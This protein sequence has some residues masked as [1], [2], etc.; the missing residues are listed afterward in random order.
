MSMKMIP[1]LILAS[2][3]GIGSISPAAVPTAPKTVSSPSAAEHK[4]EL[5]AKDAGVTMKLSDD[6]Q[7]HFKYDSSKFTV[8]DS[9]AKDTRIISVQKKAGAIIRSKDTV[10]VDIPNTTYSSITAIVEDAALDLHA[11]NSDLTMTSRSG[12]VSIF[13]PSK[14]TKTVQYTSDS[15]A[16]SIHLNGN[17][18]FTVK[19]SGLDS[20]ASFPNGWP[21]WKPSDSSIAGYSYQ[22][23]KG[24]AKFEIRLNDSAL[25]VKE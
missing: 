17:A 25:S 21:L 14:F 9:A 18:N 4:I 20:A 3:L 11:V 6:G 1:V 15:G 23:G 2:L 24:T 13:L 10:V 22:S 16:A 7:F 5:R 19:V 12:A 8:K